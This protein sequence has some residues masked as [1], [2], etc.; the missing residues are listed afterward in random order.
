[1]LKF[2]RLNNTE[3]VAPTIKQIPANTALTYAIGDPLVITEGKAA[4][5]TKDACTYVCAEA[6]KGKAVISAYLVTEGM[7]LEEV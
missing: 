3:A 4:K 6:A 7:E 5:S 1:M 2:K